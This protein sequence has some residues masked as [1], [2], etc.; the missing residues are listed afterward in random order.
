MPKPAHVSGAE[1]ERAP[2]QL[3]LQKV[4]L[5]A[6]RIVLKRGTKGCVVPTHSEV[7]I[8]T[9]AGLHRQAE[10]SPEEFILALLE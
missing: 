3:G 8:G 6:S 7:R 2:Q 1:I 5:S 10:V 9:L 4:R